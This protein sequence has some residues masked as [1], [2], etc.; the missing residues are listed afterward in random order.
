MA[1]LPAFARFWMVCRK[2][3]PRART[4]PR[5]RYSVKAD[6]IAAARKLAHDNDHPFILLEA[7]E[8]FRPGDAADQEA[9]L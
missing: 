2:P 6:A 1:D 5:Q 8:I 4:E 7:V 3:G 9:L